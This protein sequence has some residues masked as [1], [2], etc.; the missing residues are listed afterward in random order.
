MAI[1][2]RVRSFLLGR[3]LATDREGHEV[4]QETRVATAVVLL[5]IA[6]SDQEHLPQ[7]RETIRRGLEVEFGISDADALDL[8]M[9]A[10]Q[11]RKD[12]EDVEM[13]AQKLR[14]RYD[15]E[16]L[17]RIVALIW[18]VVYTDRIVDELE[19]SVAE[20]ITELTGLTHQ[21]ALDAAS[22]SYVWGSETRAR[23]TTS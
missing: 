11:A 5:E 23:T 7:E 2:E 4:D 10:E 9:S 14:E 6:Y 15:T 20:H 19:R 12:Q 21:Q 13:L 8:I 16:Q 18:R 17:Q 1:F 3:P 22:K